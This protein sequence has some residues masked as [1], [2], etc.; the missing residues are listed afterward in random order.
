MCHNNRPVSTVHSIVNETLP[1][2]LN[3]VSYLKH[4]NIYYLLNIH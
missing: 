1:Q 4:L 2:I 3:S